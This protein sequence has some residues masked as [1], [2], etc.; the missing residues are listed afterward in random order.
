MVYSHMYNYKISNIFK[1]KKLLTLFYYL[2]DSALGTIMRLEFYKDKN[3]RTTTFFLMS[4]KRKKITFIIR[5]N[6]W[7][8][9]LSISFFTQALYDFKYSLY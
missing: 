6:Y 8:T 9:T 2:L 7:F 4:M 5:E 3:Y 1:N